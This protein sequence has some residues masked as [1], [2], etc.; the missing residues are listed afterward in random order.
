MAGEDINVFDTT[1]YPALA[2]VLDRSKARPDVDRVYFPEGSISQGTDINDALSI[3]EAKRNKV[4]GMIA[5]DG[6]RISGADVLVNS[7]A[8]TV[9]IT[10]GSIF[11]LGT[12]RAISG[13]TLTGVPMTGDVKIGLRYVSTP[14]TGAD[15]A[16]FL[17]QYAG[18]E[19]SYGEEGAVRTVLSFTWGREG[20]GGAGTLFPYVVLRNGELISQDAPPTLS[21]VQQQIAIYDYDSHENYIARGCRVSAL[22]NTAG[23]QV[24]SIEEGTA[25]ILGYKLQRP[26]STRFSIPEDADVGTV[27]AEPHTF[28]DNLTGTAVI[29]LRHS[30]I[31]SISS[32][33][34]T[35]QRT[36]T[37][38]KGATNS[39]DALPDDS[40][41][42][43]LLVKQGATTYANPADYFQAGDAV[44]W[45]PGGVEPASG[46]SYDVT[47]KY[48]D[49]VTP[50]AF[51]QTTITVSG[52]VSSDPVIVSYS[53]KLPRVDRVC[54]DQT[55]AVVYLKGLSAP[56]QAQPPAV[57]KTVVNLA[58]VIN[59]W[60]GTPTVVNDGDLAVSVATERKVIN[61]LYDLLDL[62]TLQKQKLDINVRA[63]GAQTGTFSDPL[64]SD[65]YR[66]AGEAQNGAVFNGSLQLPIIPE[67]IP[68]EATADLLLNF[69]QETV[70]KQDLYS[71]CE[72]INP[73]QVFAPLP[74]VITISPSKDYWTEQ[75]TVWLSAQTQVFGSGNSQR[76]VDTEIL[77]NSQT[78]PIQY[79][80]QI[81]IS[82]TIKGLGA[83]E[84]VTSLTFDGI[85]VNPGSLVANPSGQVSG[86]FLIPAN[87]VGGTKQIVAV[88]ASGTVC[89]ALF[90]GQGL[91]E[92]ITLQQVTTV[93]RFQQT[94]VPVRHP[95]TFNGGNNTS[96][97]AAH[98]DPQAQSFSL[99]EGRHISSID[100]QFCAIGDRSEPVL[101]DVVTMDNG[102][103]TTEII[104]QAYVDMNPVLV[105]QWQ[106]FTFDVPFFLPASQ[107]FAFVVKTND[108]NHSIKAGERGG[109]D[110]T[111]Q[112]W[113]AGQ[114]YTVGTR[115]SSS[116]AI[117]WTVHQDSDLMFQI[118][119]ALFSP[120][121]KTV[122]LGNFAVTDC[123]DLII[124]AD[125]FLPTDQ[126]KVVFEV[127]F[128]SEPVVRILPDQVWE[129][130]SFF[131]GT[132]N[133][134]AVLT[135]NSK[136]SPVV[137][138]S[139]LMIS[140]T[141]QNTG[142]YVS[143]SWTIGTAV[144]VRAIMSTKLPVGSTLAVS[145]D[146]NN[147]T[148][149]AL[150]QLSASPI[151]DGFTEREYKKDPYT[152]VAGRLK[153]V[154][155][156]TPAARP[157][158]A[159]VRAFTF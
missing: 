105:N 140:G 49:A 3:E 117:S 104:A 16:L 93:Q 42:S 45:T 74:A 28:D 36:V 19:E 102:F 124:R 82:F 15:D 4:A 52:G 40:V 116:N 154:L 98:G 35:K 66:D 58:R 109:F 108:P 148:F 143:R 38:T 122:N 48:L 106:R 120:V 11:L 146:A 92:T 22:G 110:A 31:A 139:I 67:F 17:G 68:I 115:F 112:Q 128:G 44:S 113:I 9:T 50:S 99:V 46:S 37:I 88:S 71:S 118:N 80:R 41:T 121:S 138:K 13:A 2:N 77:Q 73:Y 6:D 123:S 95:T 47:Y 87:V 65:F 29:A 62:V 10:D 72:K 151:D 158:V 53:F 147:D 64:T 20:D 84:V 126:T 7:S 142:E 70:I 91:L 125:V 157:S 33:V 26:V 141:L 8:G 107:M 90:V 150:T 94:V 21:G 149:A 43:I 51:S 39:V 79:L 119:C 18:A 131:T 25:N 159:D 134:K 78:A 111:K 30:P 89:S 57:P 144:D 59:D 5:Q 61:K 132:V 75:Q 14:V 101:I 55:G 100:I 136:V 76:V 34:I 129:R 97:G 63:A 137:S 156:G 24:F 86:S 54:L 96:N 127:T 23:A 83:G 56:Q 155:T 103:P 60:F 69:T 133:V 1:T 152:A 135:G 145:V 81:P 85:D 12:P 27:D 153:L 114:P 32:V 130:D